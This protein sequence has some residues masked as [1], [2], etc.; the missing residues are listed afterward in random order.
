MTQLPNQRE[1]AS[2]VNTSRETVSR[3]L[4]LLIKG[5][6]LGKAGHKLVVHKAELLEKLAI[7]GLDALPTKS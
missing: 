4:Q 3:A 2:I 7:D 5:G 6:V 1:I